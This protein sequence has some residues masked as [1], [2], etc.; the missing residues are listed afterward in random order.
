MLLVV[1]NSEDATADYFCRRL[2]RARLPFV[3]LDSDADVRRLRVAYDERGARLRIHGRWYAPADFANVWLRR[4]RPIAPAAGRDAAER[5]HVA[6]EWGEALEGFL[7]HI[8]IHRWINHPTANVLASHKLE[9]LTRAQRLG[10]AVP[11]TLVTQDPAGLRSF[12]RSAKGIVTK[13][14]ASG[15]LE[16]DDGRGDTLIYTNEVEQ[17]HLRNAESVRAC[18]TLFQVRISKR[19]DVRMCIVDREILTV[20]MQRSDSAID[21][22]RDNMEGVA[23]RPV[24]PP[25]RTARATR[26]LLSS[27]GLRFAALDFVVDSAG[28]WYFLE[29][30]PNGQW[31][32]LDLVGGADFAGQFCR[33]LSLSSKSSRDDE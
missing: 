17:R 1:T 28:K 15:Y 26:R 14:L 8:P 13:P 29:L 19:Y 31:A 33:A 4:P 30:N 9:Q 22:R 5:Q 2:R 12:W 23:Y 7:A 3:R 25:V 18:P 10:L 27:Y 11:Q 6:A 24:N 16:R 32:W 20:A 21:V